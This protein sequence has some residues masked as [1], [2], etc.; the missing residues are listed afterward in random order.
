MVGVV[1]AVRPEAERP[2]RFGKS[3]T[4]PYIAGQLGAGSPARRARVR[5]G[6]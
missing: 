1:G 4:L 3:A 2:Q 5:S 6:S